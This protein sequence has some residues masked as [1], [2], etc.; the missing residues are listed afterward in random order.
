MDVMTMEFS[1]QAEKLKANL[2]DFNIDDFKVWHNK[3]YK[4]GSID[5]LN[6]IMDKR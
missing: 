6:Y 4:I 5:I 3:T 2:K 1:E